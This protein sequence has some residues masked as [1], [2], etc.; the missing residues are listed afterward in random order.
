MIGVGSEKQLIAAI[1]ESERYR[2]FFASRLQAKVEREEKAWVLL[3][4]NMGHYTKDLIDKFFYIVDYEEGVGWWF[5]KMLASNK[6]KILEVPIET[7]SAWFEYICFSGRPLREIIDKSL[8]EDHIN[9]AGQGLVTLLLYLTDPSKYSIWL[10]NTTH[11]GLFIIRRIDEVRK[12]EWGTQ[13]VAFNNKA[14]EFT[15]NYGFGHRETDF[16]LWFIRTYVT[17]D[18]GGFNISAT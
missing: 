1:K 17:Y 11:E 9:G 4:T 12:D 6:K 2:H 13:Y 5:G 10:K 7:L 15:R 16:I 18:R 8:V 14:L 3:R